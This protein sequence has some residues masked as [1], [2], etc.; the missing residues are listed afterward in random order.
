[1]LTLKCIDCGREFSTS[2]KRHT[3]RCRDC[4]AAR[5]YTLMRRRISKRKGATDGNE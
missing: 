2:R 4:R 1:M 5:Y 3:K